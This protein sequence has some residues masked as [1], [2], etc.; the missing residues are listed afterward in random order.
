[1]NLTEPVSDNKQKLKL[2]INANLDIFEP[3]LTIIK[4]KEITQNNLASNVKQQGEQI[5][6]QIKNMNSTTS[7]SS[8]HVHRPLLL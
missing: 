7:S 1:M 6:A 3:N 8:M 2:V 5:V 4:A